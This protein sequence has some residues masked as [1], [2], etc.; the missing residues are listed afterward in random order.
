MSSHFTLD[1]T[2]RDYECDMQ[3]IVNNA[4]YQNYLEHTRHEFLHTHGLDF[5]GLTRAGV[6]MVVLRAELDY[7]KPLT[8]GDRF[9]VELTAERKTRLKVIFYQQIIRDSDG[10]RL[11]QAKITTG[12]VPPERRAELPAPLQELLESLPKAH[13]N[14]PGYPGGT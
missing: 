5:A 13:R 14:R 2:V 10:Q 11:L 4:I 9:R 12:I 3:G 8:S 7:L 1:F 6:H